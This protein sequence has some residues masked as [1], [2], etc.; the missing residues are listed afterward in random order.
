[1]VRRTRLESTKP[2]RRIRVDG[3]V[4]QLYCRS[5]QSQ[6]S[7]HTLVWFIA[8]QTNLLSTAPFSPRMLSRG[9]FSLS[10]KEKSGEST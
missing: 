7:D 6:P 2:H 8:V 1:M 9:P 10:G 4:D 3:S 5:I